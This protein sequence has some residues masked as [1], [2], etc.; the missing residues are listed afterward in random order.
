MNNPLYN[1]L[2]DI[3]YVPVKTIDEE[4]PPEFVVLYLK[5]LS[6]IDKRFVIESIH[7]DLIE[8]EN[9]NPSIEV[10]RPFVE[11]CLALAPFIPVVTIN[12][13]EDLYEPSFPYSLQVSGTISNIEGYQP[14]S[15]KILFD[16]KETLVEQIDGNE[17]STTISITD[18]NITSLQTITAVGTSLE[19]ATGTISPESDRV[20]S[21]FNVILPIKLELIPVEN[22]RITLEE[23]LALIPAI[24]V[25]LSVEEIL[26]LIPVENVTL[27]I[28]SFSGLFSDQKIKI[29]WT[30]PIQPTSLQVGTVKIY[31]GTSEFTL[32]NVLSQTEL[33]TKA[34]DPSFTEFIDDF[35]LQEDTTYYYMIIVY[36]DV[37]PDILAAT[38][39]YSIKIEA[40]EKLYLGA[41]DEYSSSVALTI[42]DWKTKGAWEFSVD[43]Q[44]YQFNTEE[45]LYDA[46]VNLYNYNIA[47][48]HRTDELYEPENKGTFS[49]YNNNAHAHTLLFKYIGDI[50]D[51]LVGIISVG[52][53]A[54]GTVVRTSD[55]SKTLEVDLAGSKYAYVNQAK[56]FRIDWNASY[57]TSGIFYVLEIN[58]IEYRYTGTLEEIAQVNKYG[59][60]VLPVLHPE[61]AELVNIRDNNDYVSISNKTFEPMTVKIRLDRDMPYT[62]GVE[63]VW[64]KDNPKG[65]YLPTVAEVPRYDEDIPFYPYG[66]IQERS[67]VPI[68]V[69]NEGY[70][71]E[72]A[73]SLPE[74]LQTYVNYNARLNSRT[75]DSLILTGTVNYPDA[76][77][78][79]TWDDV[80][81]TAIIGPVKVDGAYAWEFTAL[82]YEIFEN[83][84]DNTPNGYIGLEILTTRK[85]EVVDK[86]H[87]VYYYKPTVFITPVTS[88]GYIQRVVGRDIVIDWGDGTVEP[89]SNPTD[90]GSARHTYAQPGNYTIKV[91]RFNDPGKLLW[92]ARN[93]IG[94]ATW[95][96]GYV[97]DNGIK[98]IVQW[99][100]TGYR[101]I[102]AGSYTLEKLPN[103]PPPNTPNLFGFLQG[104]FNFDQDLNTWSEIRPTSLSMAFQG[105]SKLT[106]IP[107]LQTAYCTDMS[108]AFEYCLLL[109]PDLS[110]WDTSNVTDMA[111][112]LSDVRNFNSDISNWEVSKVKNFSYLFRNHSVFNYD[113]SGWDVSQ[114]TIFNYM[115]SGTGLFNQPLNDWD[116]G[117]ATQMVGMF[118]A[119][120]AFNQPLNNWDIDSD[121]TMLGDMFAYSRV[122]NA[123]IGTWKVRRSIDD[124]FD[125]SR[126]FNQPIGQWP[127]H[128]LNVYSDT[129][130]NMAS[131]FY[132]DLSTWVVN[133]P[134]TVVSGS[135]LYYNG[136]PE[137]Y[138]RKL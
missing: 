11:F 73:P 80:K 42:S 85:L 113:I 121:K 69:T 130:F 90:Y 8:L 55:E 92:I 98:E 29:N 129:M 131:A 21:Q 2:I 4:L 25:N 71:F 23:I 128:E 54:D 74:P 28:E 104:S 105:C 96:S 43:G 77:V 111:Y 47:Y 31:R 124:M 81:Y 125:Q 7:N 12:K 5:N 1:E 94:N 101:Q 116:V 108:R 136:K 53:K 95:S 67:S 35:E 26:T 14:N 44:P 133:D 68:T 103:H 34:Y 78:S 39:L 13:I 46:L 93:T 65:L 66:I 57:L 17:W 62:N 41:R 32:D 89:L 117:K 107:P 120:K 64:S 6:Q 3:D 51:P 91:D 114:G 110:E 19:I 40:P 27:S 86:S 97:H 45:T 84:I 112:M 61:L 100:S 87:S 59:L 20:I 123:D 60:E 48:P 63:E 56:K 83:H 18:I 138:P 9:N 132:Q 58:G 122:F 24:N 50:S 88:E 137:W 126:A 15:V 134:E 16:G 75:R 70:A 118:F 36:G 72:L 106:H 109:E 115:F 135:L 119:T 22:V 82:P 49:L 37:A 79:F 52:Y 102:G 99:E 127:V 10:E 76:E 38:D 30:Y 33:V